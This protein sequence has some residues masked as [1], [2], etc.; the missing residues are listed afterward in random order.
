MGGSNI[1]FMN[2]LDGLINN[3]VSPVLIVPME[4]ID[5]QFS[6]YIQKH[7][8]KY[9]KAHLIMSV[10]GAPRTLLEIVKWPL[11]FLRIFL[12][13]IISRIELAKIIRI[14]NPDIIHTN[15]GVIHEGLL[16]AN[17]MCIPHVMHLREYQDLGFNW[18]ILPSKYYYEKLLRKSDVIISISKGV[19]EHFQLQNC[20][21]A[22]VIYN[23]IFNKNKLKFEENKL[24]Y[25]LCLSRISPE[26]RQQDVIEAFAEFYK[27][28]TNYKLIIAGFGQDEYIDFLKEKAICLGCSQSVEFIGFISDVFPYLTKARGLIVASTLE[29]FGR[30]TAEAYFAGCLVIGRDTGGTK[31]I[32]DV[33]VGDFRFMS[34]AE[35]ILQMEKLSSLTFEEYKTKV[36][37]AQ[38][39][40]AEY[41]SI[42]Q[43]VENVYNEYKFLYSQQKNVKAI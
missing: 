20:S 10:I 36:M 42:E 40:V 14:E 18:R 9:Y 41:F 28:H 33:V 26:K 25:F 22:K 39:K 13:K 4:K 30:M 15:V 8:I 19:L 17:S 23:G 35:L 16:L 43:N 29:G 24:N 3:G 38:N 37:F 31:E 12:Y 2:M 5:N 32:M 6:A 11:R 27:T 1:S 34:T 7:N 21:H